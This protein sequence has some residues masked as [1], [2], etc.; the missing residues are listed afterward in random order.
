AGD[1]AAFTLMEVMLVLVILVVIGSLGVNLV[2]GQQRRAQKQAAQIEIDS[3]NNAC[4]RFHIDMFTYPNTLEELWVN[5]GSPNW[6]GPYVKEIGPDP[7]GNPYQYEYDPS[8]ESPSIWS[9]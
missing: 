3:A 4:Q 9:F 2:T 8:A 7:W 6:S 5:T 1:R